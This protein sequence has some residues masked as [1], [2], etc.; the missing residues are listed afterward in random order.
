MLFSK[1]NVR[2]RRWP[3]TRKLEDRVSGRHNS[4]PGAPL[5]EEFAN[6]RNEFDWDLHRGMRRRFVRGL[7]LRDSFFVRLRLI[8]F[9]DT[10]D[11]FLIPTLRKLW[12]LHIYF[13]RIYF[14]RRRRSAFNAF[15]P[16]SYAV[17][18]NAE[19]G[20]GSGT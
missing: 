1:P 15:G 19:F 5:G 7:V 13:L 11:P 3:P 14:L 18:T 17:I 4:L 6:L 8:M 2:F 12:L 9:E 20:S 10:A 16:S